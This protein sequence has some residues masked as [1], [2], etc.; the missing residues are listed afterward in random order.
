M[1][2]LLLWLACAT[3]RVAS[4]VGRIERPLPSGLVAVDDD[5]IPIP[6]VELLDCRGQPIP[7]PSWPTGCDGVEAR[8]VRGSFVSSMLVPATHGSRPFRFA[9]TNAWFVPLDGGAP[10]EVA[11]D[12]RG[13]WFSTAGSRRSACR[14]ANV[15]DPERALRRIVR[16]RQVP[17]TDATD[18]PP[19]YSAQGS[20]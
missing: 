5:G 17:C 12:G 16:D 18:R 13:L 6:N 7:S 11:R 10:W 3:P 9:P 19:P 15:G 8:R 14:I 4:D 1:T 2:L 20:L